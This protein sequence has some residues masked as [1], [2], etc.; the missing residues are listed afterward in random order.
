MKEVMFQKQLGATEDYLAGRAP[1]RH[2]LQKL[3][4]GFRKGAGSSKELKAIK[5]MMKRLMDRLKKLFGYPDDFFEGSTWSWY[6][7]IGDDEGGGGTTSLTDDKSPSTSPSSESPSAEKTS[8]GASCTSIVGKPV[9]VGGKPLPESPMLRLLPSLV[10]P[11]LASA[12]VTEPSF[13]ASRQLASAAFVTFP[14]P[15]PSTVSPESTRYDFPPITQRI[16]VGGVLLDRTAEVTNTDVQGILGAKCDLVRRQLIFLGTNGDI[17]V[18]DVDLDYLHTAMKAIYGSSLPPS[19]GLQWPISLSRWTDNG[20]GDGVFEPGETGSLLLGYNP[21]WYAED[22]TVDL[23]IEFEWAGLWTN[24][25]ARLDCEPLLN[26]SLSGDGPF[27]HPMRMAFSSWLTAPPTGINVV[28]ANWTSDAFLDPKSSYDTYHQDTYS[29]FTLQNS[30]SGNYLID[31]SSAIA[32]RLHRYFGGGLENSL[33]GWVLQEADRVAGNLVDGKDDRLTGTPNNSSTVPVI[34]YLSLKERGIRRQGR[35]WLTPT[36]VRLE[37]VTD[38]QTGLPV[39]RLTSPSVVPHFEWPSE[40]APAGVRAF[41]DHFSAHFDEF[42]ALSYPCIDPT[43]PNSRRLINVPIVQMLKQAIKAVAL[44]RY[45]RE[46]GT[47]VNMWW[48]SSWNPP[49]AYCPKSL[50][51][52]YS[53]TNGYLTPVPGNLPINTFPPTVADASLADE[54]LD[55]VA[56]AEEVDLSFQSPGNWGLDFVRY[57][58]STKMGSCGMGPGWSFCPFAMEFEFP[59]WSD[60]WSIMR[61]ASGGAVW[62]DAQFD[63]HL[64]TGAFRVMDLG[65]DTWLDFNSSL[66]VSYT[67]DNYATPTIQMTGL[68]GSGVPTFSAGTRRDGSTLIQIA[69]QRG[70]RLDT[71]AGDNLIF[72]FM[73]RLLEMTDRNGVTQTFT[74]NFRGMLLSISDQA[75]QT[76]TLEYEPAS[77]RLIRVTGPQS[78]QVTYAYTTNGCLA[79]ATH[80]RSGAR[81]EYQYNAGRQLVGKRFYNGLAA[82]KGDTDLLG[83]A[84][85]VTD[86]R[87][88]SVSNRFSVSV[89]RTRYTTQTSDPLVSD[90]QFQPW[91]REFDEKGRLIASRDATQAETLFGYVDDFQAPTS[92]KLPIS[93]RPT[94]TIE[95]NALGQPTRIN[96]P[97]NLGAQDATFTYDTTSRLPTHMTD[98]AGRSINLT[99]D[100]KKNVQKL[101]RRLGAQNVDVNF[102]YTTNGALSSIENP[103]GV[104]AVT[105]NRDSLGRATNVVDAT[106]I[107]ISYQ[108]DSLGRLR[109][110][111]DPRLSTPVE[112]IYDN[113]DRVTEIRYPVGSVFYTYDPVMGWLVSQTDL[114]G[115]VTRYVRDPQTG[116]VMQTIDEVVGGNNRVTTMTYNRYG[117]LATLTPPDAQAISFNYDQLGRPLGSSEMN[118]RPPGAPKVIVSNHA[119]DGIPTTA[120]DHVFTWGAPD[121]DSGIADYS[122]A[123]DQAPDETVDT[124]TATTSWSGVPVGIHTVQARAK[125]NNGL[126]GES[127]V[128]HLIV[129]AQVEAG[130][131]PSWGSCRMATLNWCLKEPP[132]SGTLSN[133]ARV[134]PD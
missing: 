96:D 22:S 115:R 131:W 98:P 9:L 3:S 119:Q 66:T 62:K 80:Q 38:I 6:E 94:I 121:S 84:T 19:T 17:P 63:T 132:V 34:A 55:C 114:L 106:G 27:P 28:P 87:G 109:T 128:F 42:A 45:L 21:L 52:V 89:N 108:F 60:E 70:Y 78:E 40:P 107:G 1:S 112:Y 120:T 5:G 90:P 51:G 10:P 93:G 82:W 111:R 118:A 49:W 48:L 99:Y 75:G 46:S 44:A 103:L 4:E 113:F 13:A 37:P 50:P 129:E 33:L 18:V 102:G 124:V 30:S 2:G 41:A 133:G 117:Q 64:R 53:P 110:V 20:D 126:W 68:N 105:I 125:G 54:V 97:G 57:Y 92:I 79:S 123:F 61:D 95:R 11:E 36:A 32:A 24:A 77:D 104:I 85:R 58:R 69:G 81:I 67:N 16:Q 8:Q 134:S 14:D 130:E 83:R 12:Q 127:C 35:F 39:F 73:G 65:T 74:Y 29:R 86:T 31:G 116:D 101:R 26:V 71:P 56:N 88:N 122:Y 91:R 76:I 59:S 100:A 15:V 23:T 25:T 43:D 47:P 72:D 7:D